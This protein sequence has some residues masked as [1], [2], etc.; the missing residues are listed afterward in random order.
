MNASQKRWLPCTFTRSGLKSFTLIEILV[1]I[2][3][4]SL[5]MVLL[6]QMM[7][8]ASATWKIGQARADN[9]T[10]SRI[11]L[12]LISRDIS[13]MVLRQDL[14]AFVD[15][16]NNP[17]CAFYTRFLSPPQ[18]ASATNNRPLSLIQYTR[19]ATNNLAIL[20][21]N[22]Y[23]FGY[24][25]VSSSAILQFQ[26]TNLPDLDPSLKLTTAQD[27]IDGV[28]AFNIQFLNID[29]TTGKPTFQNNFQFNY[30]NA[31][32]PANTRIV[33]VSIAVIDANAY[34][35]AQNT[36]KLSALVSAFGG[37]PPTGQSYVQYW[38]STVIPSPTFTAFIPPIRS[39]VRV[40]ERRIVIPTGLIQLN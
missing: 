17:T 13:S 30:N 6:T 37:T 34:Q 33:I 19:S 4:L 7:S 27:L 15:N 28:I 12:G 25:N 3:V 8:L 36:S 18:S 21:R 16:Q 39:G 1:S 29:P 5:I 11:V 24:P 22:D 26:Q 2:A 31:S 40:F 23:G 20:W 9:F 10:Q 35:L 38:N 32:D 14:G